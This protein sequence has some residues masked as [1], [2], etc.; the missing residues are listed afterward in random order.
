[1]KSEPSFLCC[2]IFLLYNDTGFFAFDF[3]WLNK[4][5]CK[6]QKNIRPYY[7]IAVDIV[8]QNNFMLLVAYDNLRLSGRNAHTLFMNLYKNTKKA[9]FIKDSFYEIRLCIIM[10]NI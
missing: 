10:N 9:H 5:G 8:K 1:M 2:Y 3:A 4:I 7:N 6:K